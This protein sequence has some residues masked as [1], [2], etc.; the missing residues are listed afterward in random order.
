VT[1]KETKELIQFSFKGCVILYP[2][3]SNTVYGRKGLPKKNQPQNKSQMHVT[4]QSS[5]QVL[6]T[7]WGTLLSEGHFD[8]FMAWMVMKPEII[9]KRIK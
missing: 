5:W 3:K 6:K 4:H 1:K 9:Q 7:F 8:H 2:C